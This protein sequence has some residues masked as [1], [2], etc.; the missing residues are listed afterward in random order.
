MGVAHKAEIG[1]G[2]GIEARSDRFGRGEMVSDLRLGHLR[3]RQSSEH[4]QLVAAGR[5]ASGRH[6]GRGVPTQH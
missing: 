2:P 6:H 1:G 3:M 4:G 5:A